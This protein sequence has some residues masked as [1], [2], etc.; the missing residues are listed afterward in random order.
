MENGA[1][2]WSLGIGLLTFIGYLEFQNLRNSFSI[3][4][5]LRTAALPL[6][7][8]QASGQTYGDGKER[9]FREVS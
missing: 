2:S 1:A 5:G 9:R 3:G 7:A 8:E 6:A 4:T